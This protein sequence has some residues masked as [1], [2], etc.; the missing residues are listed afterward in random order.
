LIGEDVE[1]PQP[2]KFP[3]VT[4]VN[5]RFL[6]DAKDLI[7]AVEHN[8]PIALADFDQYLRTRGHELV[9]TSTNVREFVAPL[10]TDN[11]FLKMRK[12]LQNLEA[13]PVCYL[14]EATILHQELAAAWRAIESGS[15]YDG[16]DPYVGRWDE[17]IFPGEAPSRIFV[18]FRLDEII[19]RLWRRPSKP[20]LMPRRHIDWTRANIERER[21]ITDAE[22]LSLKRNFIGS[23]GRHLQVG[24]HFRVEE[25]VIDR[26]ALDGFG[27][28]IYADP[29]RCPGFRLHYN[30]Y[31]ELVRNF[32]DIPK[33]S[34]LLDFAHIPAIPYIDAITMDRR[35]TDYVTRVSRRLSAE[36]AS[37]NYGDRI[38]P[39]LAPLLDAYA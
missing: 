9:L 34:D 19:H 1:V 22:R 3:S 5:V 31:H 14:R 28:W 33:D 15:N 12:L 36:Y 24:K 8:R 2:R 13:L 32:R 7:D 4:I 35:M 16:I 38:F 11:D 23:V 10:I 25:T 27:K 17:T 20:L 18:T 39:K 37:T 30:T 29:H 6:L 26:T 21:E